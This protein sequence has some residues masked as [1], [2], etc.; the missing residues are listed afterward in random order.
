MS[1]SSPPKSFQQA[2]LPR[3][4]QTL[5]AQ[6]GVAQLQGTR[7]DAYRLT[8]ESDVSTRQR[9]VAASAA[10]LLSLC[11]LLLAWSDAE[12]RHAGGLIPLG[13]GRFAAM[14][15]DWGWSFAWLLSVLEAL[16]F[17]GL[18]AVFATTVWFGATRRPLPLPR[19]TIIF[20]RR[21]SPWI[22]ANGAAV[23]LA[24]LV[25]A[26][27][28]AAVGLPLLSIPFEVA[29]LSMLG[30]AVWQALVPESR[31][32]L[33]VVLDANAGWGN[34][35]LVS[36]GVFRLGGRLTVLHDHFDMA[37][38]RDFGGLEFAAG[39]RTLTLH[40]VGH[41]GPAALR[42]RGC[43]PDAEISVL[44]DTLN[45]RFKLALTREMV[46]Q[47]QRIGRWPVEAQIL[48]NGQA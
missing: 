39:A 43:G 11:A 17:A 6:V 48:I 9:L 3:P 25:L 41:M 8:V 38:V 40:Y 1:Q 28:L 46:A 35:L 37:S 31:L 13:I 47:A 16:H 19:E 10:S 2:F 7:L 23:A 24:G 18:Y 21:Q 42:I 44:A 30:T 12:S 32:A 29:C 22:A 27:L 4:S 15:Q 20:H 36:G 26:Q 34:R 45:T 33:S 14:A 5:P